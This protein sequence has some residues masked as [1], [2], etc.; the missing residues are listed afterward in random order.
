M[1][2]DLVQ[3]V[4]DAALGLRCDL[5]LS[6]QLKDKAA[7]REE[8]QAPWETRLEPSGQR[9]SRFSSLRNKLC[10]SKGGTWQ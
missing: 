9:L 8:T 1:L 6:K 4:Q 5:G 7:G 2:D 3:R 10:A